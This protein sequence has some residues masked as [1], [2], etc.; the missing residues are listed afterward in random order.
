LTPPAPL[1]DDVRPDI[2]PGIE[3]GLEPLDADTLERGPQRRCVATGRVADKDAL[4]R[5][6][7][8]PAGQLVPDLQQRLPGRGL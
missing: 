4:L 6:V 7:V 8:A 2:D 3:P 1:A 5:F